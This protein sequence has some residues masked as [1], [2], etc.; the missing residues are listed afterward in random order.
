MSE[1]RS[2]AAVLEMCTLA[3][4]LLADEVERLQALEARL[5]KTEDGA[6]M[7]PGGHYW[8]LCRDRWG[9]VE[10]WQLL[11]VVW[12]QGGGDDCFNPEYTLADEAD[13]LR[14]WSEFFEV[15]K[16]YSTRE[17]AQTTEAQQT[18]GL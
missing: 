13:S 3:P 7:L 1:R 16:V 4:G 11:E 9:E 8:A 5:P 14:C 2:R 6:P 12:W 10:S 18:T 15:G 17:T